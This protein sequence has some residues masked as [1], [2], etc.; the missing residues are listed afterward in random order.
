MI[1]FVKLKRAKTA[2][3]FSLFSSK[4]IGL[5]M[6]LSYLQNS[7][8]YMLMRKNAVVGGFVINYTDSLRYVSAISCIQTIDNINN[9]LRQMKVA[10]VTGLW[11]DK[12]YRKSFISVILWLSI[13]WKT[14]RGGADYY[15]FATTSKS[16]RKAMTYPGCVREILK[17]PLSDL[18][19]NK[20]GYFFL[21]KRRKAIWG[22]IQGI[23]YLK[24]KS[25]YK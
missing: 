15:L 7:K 2:E 13:A 17:T 20:T 4:Y 10:E 12:N 11:L 5:D 16:L 3:D 14:I 23:F 21:A 6:P 9:K 19:Q 24:V 1:P 25:K 18:Y 8:T 22:M